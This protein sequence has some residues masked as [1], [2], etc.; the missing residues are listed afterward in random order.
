ML[1]R[2]AR[3]GDPVIVTAGPPPGEPYTAYAALPGGPVAR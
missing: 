2:H 3:L 1:F